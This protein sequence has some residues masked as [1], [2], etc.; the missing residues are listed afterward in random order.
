MHEENGVCTQGETL[1]RLSLSLGPFTH[2]I[3]DAIR[4]QNAPY[5][6][7]HKCFFAKHRVD[8]N[9][10]RYYL[11]RPFF[12]VSANDDDDDDGEL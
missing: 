11:K 8:R 5:P 3:F 2:A 12:P 7:L 6:T 10:P 9:S 1:S 4:E